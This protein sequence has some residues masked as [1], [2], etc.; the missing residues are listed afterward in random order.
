LRRKCLPRT[1]KL[2]K[3]E[4]IEQKAMELFWKHGFKKIT[5]DEICKKANVSRKTFYTFFDNKNALIIYLY[6]KTIDQAYV[7]YDKVIKSD[8]SFSEKLEKLLNQKIESTKNLSME[9]V[10][11]LYH[12][13][14]GELLTFFNQVIEQ[15]MQFMRNFLIEAQ[16][17]GDIDPQLNIDYI[18]FI[19][20]KTIELCGTKEMMDMFPNASTMTKQISQTF[21]FGIAPLNKK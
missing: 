20:S 21:I 3:K 11:D 14:A 7:E 8:I 4:Q 18:M 15:S 13:D 9:F 10:A 2:T 19:L 17:T 16:K 6:S 5:I 12:P 1:M